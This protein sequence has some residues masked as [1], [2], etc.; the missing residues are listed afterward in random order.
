MKKHYVAS[1]I[2]IR[3]GRIMMIKHPELNKWLFPGGHVEINESPVDTVLREVMEE[4]GCV[5]QLK[6]YYSAVEY[7]DNSSDT[8]CLP[9]LILQEKQKD[10]YHID[11]IYVAEFV[12]QRK[13]TEKN[14]IIWID[15]NEYKNLDTFD[16]V[17]FILDNIFNQ[18]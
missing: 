8:I 12:E 6:N 17:L 7:R 1:A 9:Y 3:N 15:S 4:V 5:I 2:I 14:E 13:S 16:N 10:H 18:I 11:F